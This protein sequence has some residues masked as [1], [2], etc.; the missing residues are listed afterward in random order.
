MAA[1]GR[2][3]KYN[4]LLACMYFAPLAFQLRAERV[5]R[6]SARALAALP[7]S[8]LCIAGLALPL[9]AFPANKRPRFEAF[10]A[11]ALPSAPRRR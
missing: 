1:C 9:A 8:A 10:G 2:R 6:I 11:R 5:L 4:C 7:D 3:L